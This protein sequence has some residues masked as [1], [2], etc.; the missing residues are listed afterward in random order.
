[1][2]HFLSSRSQFEFLGRD[3]RKNFGAHSNRALVYQ[4]VTGNRVV[5]SITCKQVTGNR[6]VQSITRQQLT[7]NGVVQ[8]LRGILEKQFWGMMRTVEEKRF[9]EEGNSN[10][11]I[12]RVRSGKS[13][14]DAKD[15]R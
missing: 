5:Q 7:D 4:Q 2:D 14:A 10:K 13:N 8:L 3:L 12:S 1:M 6:V 11:N 15:K 9:R